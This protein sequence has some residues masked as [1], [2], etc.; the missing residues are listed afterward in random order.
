MKQYL[1]STHSNAVSYFPFY[2]VHTLLYS[3]LGQVQSSSLLSEIETSFTVLTVNPLGHRA[4]LTSAWPMIN[5]AHVFHCGHL[6]LSSNVVSL[7]PQQHCSWLY[8]SALRQIPS[9]RSVIQSAAMSINPASAPAKDVGDT[10][11]GPLLGHPKLSTYRVK[12]SWG[13][14]TIN[15]HMGNTAQTYEPKVFKS[16]YMYVYT[17]S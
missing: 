3:P 11:D 8:Q 10:E 4:G 15:G 5:S 12:D 2:P 16:Y 6:S 13:R 17:T 1:N 14:P 9:F 7:D